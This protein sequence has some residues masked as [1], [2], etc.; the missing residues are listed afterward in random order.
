MAD[1]VQAL[2]EREPHAPADQNPHAL[3]PADVAFPELPADEIGDDDP[4]RKKVRE[5]VAGRVSKQRLRARLLFA[6][7]AQHYSHGEIAELTGLS[8]NAVKK[9]LQRARHAGILNDQ[10][11]TLEVES[12]DLAIDS[13][14]YHLRRRDKK[15]TLAHLKGMGH[16]RNYSNQK[17]EG[18]A[19]LSM[20]PLQ[21]NV[22]VQTGTPAPAPD[23]IDVSDGAIGVPRT[24]D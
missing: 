15:V 6:L 12:T 18:M 13:L 5:L 11:K 19:G 21:V 10:R 7:R 3:D 17:N 1:P 20:P 2:I 9:A 8:V 24:D 23:V 16:Y 22:T 4:K 14:N